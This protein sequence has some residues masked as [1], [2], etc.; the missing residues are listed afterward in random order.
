VVRFE[1]SA[2]DLRNTRLSFSPLWEAVLSYRLLLGA[3]S[4]PLQ[5]AW[6]DRAQRAARPLDLRTL[7]ALLATGMAFDFMLPVPDEPGAPI[8]EE[9]D[10]MRETA[11]QD[12]AAEIELAHSSIGRRPPMA[13]QPFV[14]H[15]RLALQRL[16]DELQA[17]WDAA[18][19][20]HWPATRAVLEGELLHGAHRHVSGGIDNLLTGLHP[21]VHWDGSTLQVPAGVGG[22]VRP[23]GRGVVFMATAFAW[24]DV[25]AGV[26]TNGTP[27]VAYQARGTAALWGPVPHD[28]GKG[29]EVLLGR[30]RAA[31]LENIR[32]PRSTTDLA[33]MLHTGASNV[34]YHLAVLRQA[35]L[36]DRHRNGRRVLYR[37]SPLGAGLLR[38][39]DEADHERRSAKRRRWTTPPAGLTDVSK[40][41]ESFPLPRPPA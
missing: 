6:A 36:A 11:V 35:G 28:P 20:P 1:L 24:P 21:D 7:T 9:L 12:V 26:S 33:R 19:A 25:T 13:L 15:S 40:S 2:E 32:V 31:V 34:S 3:G 23:G 29:L 18:M 17:Y 4:H 38:L 22:A 39:W 8:E 16:A 14:V 10:R 30:E 37:L 41:V 27:L 5:T